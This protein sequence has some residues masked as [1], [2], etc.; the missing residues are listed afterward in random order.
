MHNPGA[1][2]KVARLYSVQHLFSDLIVH[3]PDKSWADMVITQTSVFPKGKHDDL[4]DTV[5]Q[6]MKHLRDMGLLVRSQERLNE[7]E[8]MK[9]LK[10][11]LAPLYG[12]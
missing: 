10:G 5:S 1:Q 11:G 4:V 12:I 8:D 2:D 3:A 7:I 9:Q 6:A